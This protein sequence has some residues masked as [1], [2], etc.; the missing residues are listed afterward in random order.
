MSS[1]TSRG[2]DAEATHAARLQMGD[3][4]FRKMI[5]QQFFGQ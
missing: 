4:A 3:E 1:A 2:T 5:K